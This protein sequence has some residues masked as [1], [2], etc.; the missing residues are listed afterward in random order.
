MAVLP[1]FILSIAKWVP[2]TKALQNVLV[3]Q[4]AMPSAMMP[5]VI[6]RHHS[7]D[8]RF[9]VQIILFSTALGLATIPLWIRFG[10]EMVSR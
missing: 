4:A 3:M 10:M 2:M 8:S 1:L 6:C 7:A 9:C 5:V